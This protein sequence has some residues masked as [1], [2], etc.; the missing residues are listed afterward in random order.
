MQGPLCAPEYQSEG[1]AAVSVADEAEAMSLVVTSTSQWQNWRAQFRGLSRAGEGA[2]HPRSRCPGQPVVALVN[3]AEES[4]D[5]RPRSPHVDPSSL[6]LM[7]TGGGRRHRRPYSHDQPPCRSAC[8]PSWRECHEGNL[9]SLCRRDPDA[10]P[11][12]RPVRIV[13]AHRRHLAPVLIDPCHAP[14]AVAALSLHVG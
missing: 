13:A 3:G 1:C 6:P 8:K 14:A 9:R 5:Q 11:S 12:H 4:A 10:I 2:V 7:L